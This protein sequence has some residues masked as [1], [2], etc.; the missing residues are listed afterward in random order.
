MQRKVLVDAAQSGYKVILESLN[1]SFGGVALVNSWWDK[2]I[3]DLFGLHELFECVG[4]F[5][6][7]S[8]QFWLEAS[9]T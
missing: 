5:V 6:V 1:C 2:L 7:K 4:A 3:I 9:M 8:L